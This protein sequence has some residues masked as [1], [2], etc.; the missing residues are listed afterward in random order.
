MFLFVGFPLTVL[1]LW[2]VWLLVKGRR[3]LTRADL[4]VGAAFLTFLATDLSGI[5]QGETGR[6]WLIFAPAWLLLASEILTR[7]QARTRF[8]L[9]AMQVAVM[10]SMAALLRVHFTALT[11]PATA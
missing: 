10:P 7:L 6:I 3:L 1:V 9:V 8:A 5:N 11:L 4:F 2:R